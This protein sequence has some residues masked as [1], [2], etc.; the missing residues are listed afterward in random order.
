MICLA[1]AEA[2]LLVLGADRHA[3]VRHHLRRPGRDG[4][5][6]RLQVV[7]EPAARIDLLTAVR[8]VRVL[9]VLLR[10]A[11]GEVL[12]HRGDRVRAEPVALEAADVGGDQSRRSGRRPRR[13][14]C[15][16]R[17]QRGSVAR[18]ICG[19]SAT[20]MPTATYSCRAMSAN[21]SHQRRRRRGPRGPGTPATAENAPAR[22]AVPGFVAERVPRVGRHRHRDA[23]G[24]VARASSWTRLCQATSSRTLETAPSRL[25]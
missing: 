4:G 19:C 3:V 9:A 12:G 23:E 8:E 18:S 13:R 14:S 15:R 5:Q 7:V 25:R 21:C 11:A 22:A 6:E 17:A 24:R 10:A 20:R 1:E 16:C 2:D